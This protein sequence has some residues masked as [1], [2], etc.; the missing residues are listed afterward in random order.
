[1]LLFQKTTTYNNTTSVWNIGP[2]QNLMQNGVL[3]SLRSSISGTVKSQWQTRYYNALFQKVPKIQQLKKVQK[4]PLSSTRKSFEAPPPVALHQISALNKSGIRP[5]FRNPAKSSS[6]QISSR[7]RQIPVQLQL[8]CIQLI[9]AKTKCSWPVKWCICNFNLLGRWKYKIHNHYRFHKFSIKSGKQSPN[10]GNT[11]LYCLFIA[12]DSIV[13]GI[14]FIRYIVLW[15]QNKFSPNPDPAGFE[16][17]KAAR[18]GSGQI[19]NSQIWYKSNLQEISKKICKNWSP[20]ETRVPRLYFC[21]KWVCRLIF[22]R[23][24]YRYFSGNYYV[25]FGHFFG[26]KSCKITEF[27]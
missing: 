26:A 7:N 1:M 18:S 5:L 10:N 11:K 20:P 25:K 14:C 8:Q 4:Y 23:M 22:G 2:K 6:I 17:L 16:F 3:G 15:S 27:C 21:W 13:N 12:A 24:L 19:W 9:M